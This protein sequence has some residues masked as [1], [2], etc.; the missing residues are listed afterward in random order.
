MIHRRT[1]L[2][3]L[4]AAPAVIRVA[5][6][7]AI[8]VIEAPIIKPMSFMVSGYDVYGRPTNE[9]LQFFAG[10]PGFIKLVN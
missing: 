4:V 7:M 3:G 1:F 8:R 5:P 2:R 6:L 9:L 10:H